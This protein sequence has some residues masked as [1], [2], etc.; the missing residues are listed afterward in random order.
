M[1][2]GHGKWALGHST[3]SG[4]FLNFKLLSWNFNGALSHPQSRGMEHK[5]DG[6]ESTGEGD[7]IK[8][9]LVLSEGLV[10]K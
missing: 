6:A 3:P 1:C 5:G 2:S 9:V 8:L 4:L 7:E 10:I